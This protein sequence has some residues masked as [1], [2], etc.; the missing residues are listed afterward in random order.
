MKEIFAVYSL[1]AVHSYDLYHIHFTLCETQKWELKCQDCWT[2]ALRATCTTISVKNKLFKF[3]FNHTL[4][5]APPRLVLLDD[6][7]Y[8][9][10]KERFAWQKLSMKVHCLWILSGTGLRAPRRITVGPPWLGLCCDAPHL[11][12]S[13][14]ICLPPGGK[15][16]GIHED[17]NC[18]TPKNKYSKYMYN[19]A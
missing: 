16:Q 3:H 6:H 11:Q 19:L 2:S 18:P 5:E 14:M 17:R 10:W 4:N 7:L 12:L 9:Q 1:A 15:P 13:S 8:P